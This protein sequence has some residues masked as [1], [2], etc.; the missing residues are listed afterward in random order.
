MRMTPEEFHTWSQHLQLISEIE[1]L[2]A[3]LRSYSPIRRVNGRVNNVTGRYPSPKMGMSISFERERVEFWAIYTM[4]RDDDI[5]GFYE[6]SSRIPL[7]YRTFLLH[8]PDILHFSRSIQTSI[9][10]LEA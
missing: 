4:E 6:Q 3:S 2:V 1:A 10:V 9:F 7:S 5:L 8:A